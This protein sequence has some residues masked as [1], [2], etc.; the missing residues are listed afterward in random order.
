[1]EAPEGDGVSEGVVLAADVPGSIGSGAGFSPDEQPATMAS[2]TAAHAIPLTR[3]RTVP[4]APLPLCSL[5]P[6]APVKVVRGCADLC[7]RRNVP[8]TEPSDQ[9]LNGVLWTTKSQTAKAVPS[10][11]RQ[12]I[13]M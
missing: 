8:E 13:R 10:I 6:T 12:E 5:I 4:C 3:R 2:S 11:L 1:M 9:P 7:L